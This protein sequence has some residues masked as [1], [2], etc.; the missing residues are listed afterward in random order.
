MLKESHKV[1]SHLLQQ[2]RLLKQELQEQSRDNARADGLNLVYLKNIV[3]AFLVKV[4]GDAA[5]DEH[6][7]L[8][9]VLLHVLKCSPAELAQVDEKV[10][11]YTSSW[12][13]RTADMLKADAAAPPGAEE[14]PSASSWLPPSFWGLLGYSSDAP[15]PPPAP[16]A[17]I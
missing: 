10:L 3:V 14:A 11:Y 8:A 6:I 9:R 15:P 13:H 7:K 12:W 17:G 1:L 4:Y 5:D 2:E 16:R